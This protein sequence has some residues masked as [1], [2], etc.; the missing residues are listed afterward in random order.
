MKNLKFNLDIPGVNGLTNV[1]NP[2]KI[3]NQNQRFCKILSNPFQ[4][5]L[6]LIALTHIILNLESIYHTFQNLPLI[7]GNDLDLERTLNFVKIEN[8]FSKTPFLAL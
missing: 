8:L 1:L 6:K 5:Q 7:L 4:S 3:S 2:K